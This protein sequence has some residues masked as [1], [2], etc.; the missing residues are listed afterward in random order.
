MD[1]STS[2][3]SF[4]FPELR[5]FPIVN[6]LTKEITYIY[7][8]EIYL[9]RI[10]NSMKLKQNRFYDN[11][12]IDL[13]NEIICQ[14]LNDTFLNCPLESRLEKSFNMINI[15]PAY[16]FILNC[17]EYFLNKAPVRKM[18]GKIRELKNQ[19]IKNQ[20]KS[21]DD[22]FY[23]PF[24]KK[25]SREI[26]SDTDYDNEEEESEEN[27][28]HMDVNIWEVYHKLK[29]LKSKENK[30]LAKKGVSLLTKKERQILE[31][32][33]S[34]GSFGKRTKSFDKII[35]TNKSI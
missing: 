4:P 23:N 31:N 15:Y 26:E 16:S 25:E 13:L 32:K 22:S 1:K 20:N 19:I 3:I 11:D 7:L 2:D 12:N 5:G 6:S 35:L 29:I 33:K 28:E 9:T 8:P 27:I 17:D 24:M 18:I 34:L 14:F 21:K 30:I 10:K